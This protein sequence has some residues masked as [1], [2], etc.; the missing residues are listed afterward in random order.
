MTARQLETAETSETVEIAEIFEI[1]GVYAPFMLYFWLFSRIDP[2]QASYLLLGFKYV[3]IPKQTMLP[4]DLNM[5]KYP[6]IRSSLEIQAHQIPKKMVLPRD[7]NIQQIIQQ[8]ILTRD[9]KQ[10]I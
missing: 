4:W 8:T 5:S 9:L 3:K 7:L 10:Q 2:P 6:S 1:V